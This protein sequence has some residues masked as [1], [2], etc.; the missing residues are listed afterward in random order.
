MTPIDLLTQAAEHRA[1]LDAQRKKD[2][3]WQPR[4][5]INTYTV[6]DDDHAVSS[7]MQDA[8]LSIAR[9]SVGTSNA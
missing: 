3:R 4:H 6:R 7:E 1:A 8:L 9:N 5:V 2:M